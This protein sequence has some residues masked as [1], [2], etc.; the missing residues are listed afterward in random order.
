MS[1]KTLFIVPVLFLISLLHGMDLVKSVS[2]P[3]PGWA[4][5]VAVSGDYVFVVGGHAGLLAY[6]IRKPEHP[7][8]ITALNTIGY[9]QNI[10]LS[11]NLAFVTIANRGISIIDVTDP[12]SPKVIGNFTTGGNPS[13]I[14]IAGN[15]AF[16][17]D[18]KGL[19]ILEISSPDFP[20]MVDSL[21][22][23]DSMNY[24]FMNRIATSF[25]LAV[26]AQKYQKVKILD[27]S[28]PF[29]VRTI[30]TLDTRANDVAMDNGF[31]YLAGQTFS[32]WDISSPAAPGRLCAFQLEDSR[33]IVISGGHALSPTD[34]RS[35]GRR[36]HG[37]VRA[38]YKRYAG[39][40]GRSRGRGC[41]RQL[42]L[43]GLPICGLSCREAGF[44]VEKR[45]HQ[46]DRRRFP[47]DGQCAQSFQ[48][49]HR[50]KLHPA[51]GFRCK[52]RHLRRVGEKD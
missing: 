4:F 33:S 52:P 51:L 36:H 18:I 7:R 15:Y 35:P 2:L 19:F 29:S 10:T 43:R 46:P 48:F 50:D 47:A 8:L 32:V 11:G 12:G 40:A 13:D 28:N 30:D 25:P 44:A 5:G 45:D 1:A 34:S 24:Q 21:G 20:V 14:S 16:I 27:I 6:D 42:R 23:R 49:K 37:P 26:S 39:P 41:V 17:T 31:L 9:A 38:C 22:L 3:M